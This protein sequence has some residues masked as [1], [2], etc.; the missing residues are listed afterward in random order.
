MP[1]SCP[2]KRA[3][4]KPAARDKNGRFRTSARGKRLLHQ[5]RRTK[6][7][8]RRRAKNPQKPATIARVDGSRAKKRPVTNV[9]GPLMRKSAFPKKGIERP[10]VRMSDALRQAG[11][12]ET[13]VAEGFV[14]VVKKLGGKGE[15]PR[16]GGETF[17]GRAE[18]MRAPPG[19][20]STRERCGR[21]GASDARVTI[22]LIH[23]VARPQRESLQSGGI[24]ST[25]ESAVEC[26]AE[27][28]AK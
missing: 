4:A 20:T 17:R 28:A 23:N 12:D 21:D 22:N 24:A 6:R 14:G 9:L 15:Q 18:G 3:D 25:G 10:R 19:S 13:T 27:G 8:N 5:A 7:G 2:K 1:T 26:A 11:M 16:H